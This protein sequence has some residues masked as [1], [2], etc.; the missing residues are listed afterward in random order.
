MENNKW[1]YFAKQ[2][3]EANNNGIDDSVCLPAKNL[4]S[5]SPTANNKVTLYFESVKRNKLVHADTV[6]MDSVLLTTVVGDAFEVANELIRFINGHPHS[7]GFIVIADDTVTTDD[8]LLADTT[9]AGVYAHGSI[10]AVDTI[11]IGS[12]T[13]D[14]KM[15]SLGIGNAAMTAISAT[16]LTVNKAYKGSIA[17]NLAMI[18]PSAAAGKA[19]DWITV[20]YNSI[21]NNGQVHTYS[22]ATDT[23]YALGSFIRV[24]SGADDNDSTRPAVVD[25]AVGNDDV[26]T[27][28]GLTD[29]DGGI[30]TTLRFINTSGAAN[31][32]AVECIVRG[33]GKQ[34]E[35][36]TA[37]FSAA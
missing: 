16:T 15:P 20:V 26:I 35:A 22:G 3:D 13:Y 25:L 2:A 8:Y 31:G 33:Q 1:L 11:T 6:A 29:G 30:G 28:T 23:N 5:I 24:E 12:A 4:V 7:D 9:I 19:G 18:I 17:T 37:A 10:T 36:S 27:L 21:V 32:W 14:A 34:I